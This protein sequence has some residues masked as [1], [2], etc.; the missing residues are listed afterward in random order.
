MNFDKSQFMRRKK[1]LKRSFSKNILTPWQQMRCSL[2]S[3]LQFSRCFKADARFYADFKFIKPVLRTSWFLKLTGWFKSYC[4]LKFGTQ[5][6]KNN[7]VPV[8]S[9]LHEDRKLFY[10]CI[11]L[12]SPSFHL[13]A[14]CPSGGQETD[15][16]GKI[17][18]VRKR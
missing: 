5:I 10:V 8:F 16:L 15:K 18:Q 13:P 6:G 2:G 4:N 9:A 1:T 17:R 11:L 3:V 12:S 14:I 7:M